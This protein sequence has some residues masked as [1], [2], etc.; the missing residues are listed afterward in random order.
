[1]ALSKTAAKEEISKL[2]EKFQKWKN[3]GKVQKW[4]EEET[5][6][7]LILPLFEAL[8]WDVKDPDEVDYQ[9]HIQAKNFPNARILFSR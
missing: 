4:K 5:I 1:M 6:Q 3:E 7:Y 8:G 2:V 9:S